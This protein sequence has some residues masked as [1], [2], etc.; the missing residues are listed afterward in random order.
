[1]RWM[2]GNPERWRPRRSPGWR[3]VVIG[4]LGVVIALAT[5]S[6]PARAQQDKVLAE[7]LFREG[8]ELIDQG[9]VAEACGKFGESY[10]LDRALGTLINL[11]LCHEKEGKTASA[12]AE[13]SDAA[14]DAAAE[15]D[16]REA[17][18][19]KHIASL[20]PELSRLRLVVAPPASGLATLDIRLDGHVLGRA[21]WS[22]PLPIDPGDHEISA[23]AD[24]KKTYTAKVTIVK[25]PGVTNVN[26]PALED[27]PAVINVK[28]AD[29]EV[30]T[31]SN[32]GKTQ[33][34]IGYIVGGAG[35][36]GLVVGAGFG[37]S[38]IS[39]KGDR[40][41]RCTADGFCEQE[42]VDK[43]K[44]ARRAATVST[45]GF[46]TG[47][48]LAAGGVVLVLTAPRG[49]ARDVRVGV[50]GHG[51]WLGGTF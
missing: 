7:A 3:R 40:D 45:I 48:V 37:L 39:L 28:P 15:K 36:V 16:D 35:A 29:P 18:A 10:R 21:A 19:R 13:F 11:A 6:T 51:V 42:G 1:M 12:W 30:A 34:L 50:H 22:S 38:A 2:R 46:I 33:R 43:D 5:M 27:A 14:A 32:V 24:G 9:K 47:G 49:K 8:R 20:L 41:A 26:I 4:A 44:D 25:G 17:F 31:D 23:A